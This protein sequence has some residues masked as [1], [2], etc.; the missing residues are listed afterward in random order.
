VSQL[1]KALGPAAKQLLTRPPGYVLELD[2]EQLDLYRFER[3]VSEADG[4]DPPVAAAKLR[5]ALALW[6]G[7]PLADLQYEP[8]A[9]SA[10]GRMEELRIAAIEKRIDAD[11][12]LGRD[13]DLVA[14]LE[15]LTADMDEGPRLC[16]GN[17]KLVAYLGR[18]TRKALR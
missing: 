7:P 12:A 13:A 5:K 8:F 16:Q 1:R 4:A 11:L 6:R 3:L 14:E 17:F 10:I 9:Q 18:T 2:R 15:T